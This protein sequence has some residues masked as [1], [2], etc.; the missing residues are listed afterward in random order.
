M[1]RISRFST[2]ALLGALLATASAADPSPDPVL[3]PDPAPDGKSHLVAYASAILGT[4]V[5]IAAGSMLGEANE[6]SNLAPWL[7]VGGIFIGPS[8]GQFYA[9]SP[10]QGLLASGARF[11]G[12]FLLLSGMFAS[13]GDEEADPGEGTG[14]VLLG[15]ALFAGGTLYSVF[16]T[17]L[18]VDRYEQRARSDAYGF[19][20]TLQLDKEGGLRPGA[21]AFA[22]F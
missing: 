13:W 19:S 1:N 14:R 2:A 12:A 7:I 8:T 18:A 6:N 20:P 17:W 3:H 4:A 5:P 22:R 15:A 11:G 9:H 21:M 10:G 16:D